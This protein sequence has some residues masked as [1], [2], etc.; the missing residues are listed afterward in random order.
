MQRALAG[1]VLGLAFVALPAAA[2]DRVPGELVVLLAPGQELTP[3]PARRA[4]A[5]RGLSE[6]RRFTAHGRTRVLRGAPGASDTD[7]EAA[8]RALVAAGIA[9]AAAPNLV[10]DLALTPNDPMLATQWYLGTTAAGVRARSAWDLETGDPGVVI[11]IIDTGVDLGHPDLMNNIWENPGEIPGNGI[12]D[13]GNGYVDDW[14]GWDFSTNDADPNPVFAVDSLLGLDTGFHGTFAAGIAAGEGNNLTGIAGIA[15]G[16]RIMALKVSDIDSDITLAAVAGAFEYAC[17]NG[18]DVISLSFGGTNPILATFFQPLVDDAVAADVVCVAAAGNAGTDETYYPAACDSV[19]AVAATTQ[20]N[21][22]AT[23]SNWGYYVDIAAP[24]ENLWSSIAR[25]YTRDAP[26]DLLFQFLYGW[27]GI[28]PYMY[29]SGTSFA[30][31]VVAGAVALVRGRYP[32]VPAPYIIRHMIETGDVVA[33]SVDIGPRL[34]VY[35]ALLTYVDVVDDIAAAGAAAGLGRAT[36]NP[37]RV[38]P[39]GA[40]VASFAYTLARDGDVELAVYDLRG[41]RVA[42]LERGLRGA[43]AHRAQWN[44]R[45]A[46]GSPVAAGLY[47]VAGTLEGRRVDGRI[48]VLR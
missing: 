13:D 4:L 25:N 41:R 11:G 36:P 6:A 44:G 14:N 28:D 19:L 34:N 33:Y 21:Q 29:N 24:G 23:F 12:D 20:A 9:R 35:N 18:A 37:L 27:N 48:T 32:G 15:W 8:G 2:R 40:A 46:T 10:L 31:P 3:E 7:L 1:A 17:A 43:G 16:C 30:C 26:N 38:G 39:G 47:F 5:A 45:D 22:W 42:E